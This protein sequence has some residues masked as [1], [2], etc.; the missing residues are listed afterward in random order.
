MSKFCD[1]PN[2]SKSVDNSFFESTVQVFYQDIPTSNQ[3]IFADYFEKNEP[4]FT[5]TSSQVSDKA[6]NTSQHEGRE[7]ARLA[8]FFKPTPYAKTFNHSFDG[9]HFNSNEKFF[10]QP[11]R[12]PKPLKLL[13]NRLN[14]DFIRIRLFL[15][16]PMILNLL[17]HFCCPKIQFQSLF[18][19]RLSASLLMHHYQS[20]KSKMYMRIYP[21]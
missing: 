20:L 15:N 16:S 4:P 12:L 10:C 18:H 11:E 13:R 2:S 7:A 19:I 17:N 21:F 6:V 8:A 14:K 1:S 9:Q 3:G 5:P